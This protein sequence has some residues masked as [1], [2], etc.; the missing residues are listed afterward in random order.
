MVGVALFPSPTRKHYHRGWSAS[1]RPLRQRKLRLSPMLSGSR[2][3]AERMGFAFKSTCAFVTALGLLAALPAHAPA[4]GLDKLF[5]LLRP[6]TQSPQPPAPAQPGAPGATPEW[7]GESG[8]SGHPL[9]TADAI[10]AAAA[11]FRSCLEGVWPLAQ[12]RGVSRATYER[13]VLPLTPDLRIMDLLDQQPEFTKS[14]WEYLDILVGDERI[15]RGRE[16][17]AQHRAAFDAAERSYGVDRFVIAAIW[18][19]ESNYGTLIGE[20]PV[21]R[22]TATLACIGRRQNF[23]REEFLSTLEILQRGDVRPDHLV[24]SWAGAFGPTQ[25][26]PTSF[27]KYAVDFDRDGRRDVVDSVPDLIAST[28]N[29]LKKDGW[30]AGQTWGYEVVVP[31]TFNF[32][33]SDQRRP[34]SVREWE[35]QGIRRPNGQ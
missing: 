24:G 1:H 14:F 18:G 9:M 5:N 20:R 2:R 11:N 12:K 26:M 17:L 19:V 31:A 4:Q 30:V 6:G 21:I 27:K 16:M 15:A 32:L 7:S 35:K 33:L 34:M 25:F 13:Y 28:A 3:I 22:S 8:A 29:N 10:R 23:F